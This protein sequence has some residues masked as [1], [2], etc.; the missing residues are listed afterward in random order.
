MTKRTIDGALGILKACLKSKTV[1]R[2]VYTS[3]G[4]AV[5]RTGKE[6]EVLDESSWSDVDFLRRFKPDG[7]SYGVSK[8]L[9]E[10]AVLEFGEQHGLDV[11]TLIPPFVVGP[12]ICAKLPDSVERALV[13]VLGT[14]T[15]YY[16]AAY[17]I[18]TP[19]PS[20]FFPVH[21]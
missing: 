19:V 4:S 6:E 8:T 20:F 14:G 17:S 11:V 5:C 21:K 3:S 1:K 15:I 16:A 10:K 7:W 9:T 2:V 18:S 12:F 13:L